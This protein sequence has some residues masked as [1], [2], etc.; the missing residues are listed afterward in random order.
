MGVEH[1]YG[2]SEITARCAGVVTS[3]R[4]GSKVSGSGGEA[5]FP[6][7]GTRTE[8]TCRRRRASSASMTSPSGLRAT[9]TSFPVRS[10]TAYVSR[11]HAVSRS[12][13][14]HLAA[15][16]ALA[17]RRR[18]ELRNAVACTLDDP[19][20]SRVLDRLHAAA[21]AQTWQIVPFALQEFVG[22]LLGS[23]P[24][25]A[26]ESARAKDLYLPLGRKQGLFAY[27]LARAAGA[28]RIV[29]FG[30]SF[31]VSTVYLAAAAR[32]AGGG[33][34][35]GSELEPSKVAAARTN[36]AEAG[37]ADIVEIREGDAR[38]T[39]RDAGGPIDFVLLDGWKELYLPLIRLLAPQIRPGG[40]VLSDNLFTFWSALAEF[41]DWMRDPANGFRS[42]ALAIGDGM[43]CS[44][45]I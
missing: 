12:H 25:A 4:R 39:L 21:S 31:G 3:G 36:L 29:E 35:I 2:G 7:T 5:G 30:T 45:R 20:V 14:L 44:V 22:G 38:E 17:E 28:R 1:E 10:T 11:D 34:V 24:S 32:D 19:T 6:K 27:A 37:L 9:T 26:E 23:K 16:G 15:V 41:R 40:L 33:V 13:V 18:S 43:E 8:R 42:L